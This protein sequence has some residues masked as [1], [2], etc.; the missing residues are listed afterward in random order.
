MAEDAQ[1]NT[2]IVTIQ[3]QDPDRDQV[4]YYFFEKGARTLQVH[5]FDIDPD[6]GEKFYF[7]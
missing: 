3:A 2:P 6:T 4:K 5:H 1:G 7:F